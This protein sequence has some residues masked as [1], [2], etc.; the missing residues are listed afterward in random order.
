M[1]DGRNGVGL[2]FIRS[3]RVVLGSRRRY[4]EKGLRPQNQSAAGYGDGP[5]DSSADRQASSAP[6]RQNPPRRAPAPSVFGSNH[7]AGP[8]EW[9]SRARTNR[10]GST[11]EPR[12]RLRRWASGAAVNENVGMML[13]GGQEI[14]ALVGA[15]EPA[16]GLERAPDR[17]GGRKIGEDVDACD[18]GCPSPRRRLRRSAVDHGRHRHCAIRRGLKNRVRRR[19][20]T[21]AKK[22]QQKVMTISRVSEEAVAA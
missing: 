8:Q 9:G 16:L 1:L 22:C 4:P 21:F 19:R 20:R 7:G 10:A 2:A 12:L 14:V 3:A 13:P 11:G 17:L 5:E 15:A 6:R 18:A